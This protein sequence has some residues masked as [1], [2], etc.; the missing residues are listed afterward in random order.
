MIY[1]FSGTG[2]SKWVAENIAKNT[3]EQTLNIADYINK[4]DISINISA[5]EVIGIVFPVYAW[6]VPEFL[7][8]FIKNINIEEGAFSFAVCTCGDEAGLSMKKL[9]KEIKLNC[10]YSIVMPNNY[11][12]GYDVDTEEEIA[13]KIYRGKQKIE[14]ISNKVR[15]RK[16]EWDVSIGSNAFLK[17][18]LVSFLFNKF[19]KNTKPFS[20][21]DT[22]ISCGLCE[23]ICPTDNITLIDGKPVWGSKCVMCLACI[24]RCPQKAI[25]YGSSTR[26]RGRY[27][28]IEKQGELK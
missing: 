4:K 13:K 6:S 11:I 2:N 1:Y 27:Y 10:A 26:N 3:G 23:K 18:N 5:G 21:D 22:C 19:A 20:V 9:S 28:F 17:S 16:D 25:Q 24:N 7:M 8:D 14:I 15:E 12:I